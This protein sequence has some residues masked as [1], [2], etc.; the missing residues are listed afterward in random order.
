MI[1]CI[2]LLFLCLV[3]CSSKPSPEQVHAYESQKKAADAAEGRAT[4]LETEKAAIQAEITQERKQ[5][6]LLRQE[7]QH[8]EEFSK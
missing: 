2:P 7:I 5:Q 8:V 6:E 3:A 4:V 1:R